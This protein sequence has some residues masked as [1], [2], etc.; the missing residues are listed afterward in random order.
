[1]ATTQYSLPLGE[2]HGQRK[3]QS[4][5]SRVETDEGTSMHAHMY[6]KTSLLRQNSG[7]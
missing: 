1:M 7:Q 2:S 3:P 5:A 6:Q 4:I